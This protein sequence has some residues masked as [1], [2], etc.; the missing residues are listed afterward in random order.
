[1]MIYIVIMAN[2]IE[3][4]IYINLDQHVEKRN[5]MENQLKYFDLDFERF[6]GLYGPVDGIGCAKSH[7]EALKLAR[8][9][10]YKNVL[11]MEDD[12]LFTV[13]KDEFDTQISKLFS[14]IP[15]FDVCMLAYNLQKGEI[16]TEYPFLLKNIEAQTASAYLVNHIMYDKLIDLYEEANVSL[17]KTRQHWIYA[18]DQIWKPLQ[19]THKWYCFT[20]PLCRQSDIKK[21]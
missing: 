13:S 12:V 4:A 3:K 7:L 10:G 21:W 19:L 20:L 1:M 18:N 17:E 16:Y 8:Q 5:V 15:D 14:T 2:S 9:R 6:P 11:I